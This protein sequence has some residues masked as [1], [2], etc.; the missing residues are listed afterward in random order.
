[1]E[2]ENADSPEQKLSVQVGDIDGVHVD[3]MDIPESD[4][5]FVR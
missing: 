2:N 4:C 3:H 1:M 5:I